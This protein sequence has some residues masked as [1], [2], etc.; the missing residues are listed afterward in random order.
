MLFIKRLMD[1]MPLCVRGQANGIMLGFT[2]YQKIT[3]RDAERYVE[4]EPV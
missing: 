1:G 4:A 2:P 3:Q